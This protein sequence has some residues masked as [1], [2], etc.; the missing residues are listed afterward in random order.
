MRRIF[1]YFIF[2]T[3]QLLIV[4]LAL[5]TYYRISSGDWLIRRVVLPIFQ[6]DESRVYRVQANL[7]YPHITNEFSVNYYTDNLGFRA[8]NPDKITNV[9]KAEDMYRILFL[10]PSF[11]FGTA[12]NYED[13][14]VT[15][16]AEQLQVE[17]KAIEVINL[18]TP[19]QPPQ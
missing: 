11:A 1:F 3:L 9:E 12:S 8:A 6:A 13:M 17:G 7:D 16:I 19:A 18:G 15:L 10:G 5:Q 4:E 14:Y 2:V